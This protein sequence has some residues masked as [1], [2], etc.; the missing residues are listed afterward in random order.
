MKRYNLTYDEMKEYCG[1]SDSCADYNA[2]H[3]KYII[4][5]NN[6]N[7]TNIVSSNRYR[8]NIAHELGHV[9][10]G[11]HKCNDKTRIYRCSLSDSEY[12]YFETEADYFAQL[13]LV[14]HAA[15]IGFRIDS[16][17]DLRDICQ[18][19]DA[20]ANKRYRQFTKWKK[21]INANDEYDKGIFQH[22]YNYIFKRTCKNCD[23]GFIQRHGKYCSIC[24]SKNTLRW[25][26]GKMIYPKFK[27]H[28]D[29]KLQEC[30][31]CGNEE[32]DIEGDY[33]QICGKYLKNFC[34]NRN[35]SNDKPL[36]TNARFCPICGCNSVFYNAG[37]L[38]EW[39][40]QEPYD[41][42]QNIPD[43]IIDEEL[44]FN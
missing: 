7:N 28:E 9:L 18:I 8:W 2:T 37:F 25:G 40:Y 29:G 43:G 24:G 14:P 32:T 17:R 11:H 38:K 12:N 21:D 42:F 6:L 34:S 31:L 39:N 5:Y 41:P 35:C 13:L 16:V 3:N 19:S 15:L 10:L 30:P 20:A 27:A 44:P 23:A 26:D 4:Y 36:P 33:C 1:T 22:Y